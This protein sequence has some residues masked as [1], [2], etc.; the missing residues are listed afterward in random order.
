VRDTVTRLSG[1]AAV[2]TRLAKAQRE[3]K[4]QGLLF[5]RQ[6][7]I[8]MTW[9]LRL[10]ILMFVILMASVTRG[11]WILRIGQSLVCPE[12]I[13]QS[14]LILVENFDTDYLV[15][16]RAA[17]LYKA[18][19]ASR[20]LIPTQVSANPDKPDKRPDTVSRG[21]TELMSRLARIEDPEIIPIRAIE[22][23]SLNAA[24]QI[25]D[26][27]T[28]EHLRSV[29]VVTS[30]YR[31]KRSYLVYHAVLP[32]AGIKVY[33]TPV[34]GLNTPANWTKTWHDIQEVTE[35]FLK[36]QFYRIYVLQNRSA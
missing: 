7:S 11:V 6:E 26:F 21:I 34:F 14:D 23:I 22:P 36:L 29:I 27:L 9:K 8:K 15:F 5:N 32:P 4:W 35:Q 12:E 28:K 17:E 31:S 19:F 13:G 1:V 24:Y 2:V 10:A 33:C 3:S 20:V 25:R 16:E 30:G 18:G